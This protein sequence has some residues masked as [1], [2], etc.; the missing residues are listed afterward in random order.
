M[1]RAGRELPMVKTMCIPEAWTNDGLMPQAWRDLYAYA[2]AVME[3]WDGPAAIAAFDGRWVLGGMDRNGLRPMR[4]TVTS[5][6][7]LIAG[8]ETGMV[9]VDEGN[10]VE[11]GRLD[12]GEMIAVDLIDGGLYHDGALKDLLDGRLPYGG[13]SKVRTKSDTHTPEKT[14]IG[15]QSVNTV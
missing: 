8:S 11:K 13:W 12:P 1:V 9:R 2:N 7:L 15:Q 3:P 14:R 10:V 5:D 4:Y 6:G